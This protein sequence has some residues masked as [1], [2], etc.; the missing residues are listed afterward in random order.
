M[1]RKPNLFI[2]GAMKSGT[3]SL[4][5]GLASHPKIFMSA[6]KESR[7]FVDKAQWLRGPGRYLKLFAKAHNE[8]YLGEAS[9][10]YTI[11]PWSK[12][13][14]K[15]IFQ[16]NSLAKIIYIM[17]D[18]FDRIVSHYRHYL[19]RGEETR[20][21][22]EAV[23]QSCEFLILSYY[24]YQLKPY[25]ES[26]PRDAVY[27]DTFES[28][29]ES[30]ISFYKRLFLWLGVDADFIPPDI[31]KRFHLSG[32]RGQPWNDASS[33]VKFA[34]YI[35]RNALFN[36]LIPRAVKNLVVK[37][38]PKNSNP[39]FNPANLRIEIDKTRKMLLPILAKWIS[40]LEEITGR[41]YDVW[42]SAGEVPSGNVGLKNICTDSALPLEL[43]EM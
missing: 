13:V 9:P 43:Q 2:V 12:G 11:L 4:Y 8:S 31:N 20:V 33:I 40:E 1:P 14:A 15:R 10:A 3:T 23:R 34:R 19:D 21:L 27:I 39:R 26:F 25:L 38:L 6:I 32:S 41:S 36:R 18:P 30:P 7:Y 5:K 37:Y 29:K 35:K 17:R 28:M 16:F 22:S 42:P 24:A